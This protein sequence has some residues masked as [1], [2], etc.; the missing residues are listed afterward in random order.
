[1]HRK[2]TPHSLDLSDAMHMNMN[3]NLEGLNVS[4][5]IAR[6]PAMLAL[7]FRVVCGSYRIPHLL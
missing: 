7:L 4:G 6:S 5:G 3:E 1:M 2:N